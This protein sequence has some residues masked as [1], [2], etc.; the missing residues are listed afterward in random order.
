MMESVNTTCSNNPGHIGLAPILLTQLLTSLVKSYCELNPIY[1]QDQ[2]SKIP[3]NDEYDFIVVGAGSAGSAIANRLSEIPEW[4]VLLIEAGPDPPME[5]NIPALWFNMLSSKYD[6]YYKFKSSEEAC[7]SMKNKQCTLPRGKMLGGSSAMNAMIYI[8][9]NAKDYNHW[10]ELGNPG[11]NY[12]SLLKYFKKL[13]KAEEPHMN[14]DIHGHDGYVNVQSGPKEHFYNIS[15]IGDIIKKSAMELHYE[16][17][18]DDVAGMKTGFYETAFT[19]KHGTRMS[20]AR[21]YLVPAKDRKNLVVMKEALVT[22]LL[23]SENKHIY[24]VEVFSFGKYKNIFS[25]KEVVVSAGAIN[26]P[27]LLML[28]GIGPKEHLKDIGINVLSDLKVGHNLQDHI[29]LFNCFIK[30][31]VS[32]APFAKTDPFYVYLTHRSNVFALPFLNLLLFSDS[33]KKSNVDDYPDL[34]F[35]FFSSP[36]RNPFLATFY[37]SVNLNSDAVKTIVS[38]N[39]NS[40]M[41]GF[42]PLIL[43]PYSRGRVFLADVSPFASPNIESGY[44][45]DKKD[46]KTLIRALKLAIQLTKTKA[47]EKSELFMLS[48]KECD[49]LS[50]VSDEYFECC[51]RNFVTTLY[52]V[53]GTCKMGPKNDP[54]AVVDAR[55]KVY[56]VSGLRVADASIMPSI[57]SGN[58]NIPTIMIG[59][60]AADMIKEDWMHHVHSDL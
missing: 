5:S 37:E 36:P 31:N 19:I 49:G 57:V 32:M 35:H 33:K 45:T 21:A 41:V 34:Q 48:A 6:W 16:Q 23:I 55:L 8:R 14:P 15:Y 39:Y 42:L 53:A 11:W 46:I 7:R 44:L 3:D 13:E 30:L 59:E 10:E 2:S 38:E 26:S 51:V 4:R 28:S 40:F 60:K 20:S 24:G 43:R 9:G 22:K 50:K 18:S 58:T 12:N 52:H 27:K 29:I 54:D 1:P 17:L 47:L 56:G 25:K